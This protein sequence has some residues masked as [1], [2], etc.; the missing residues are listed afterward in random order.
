MHG[1]VVPN[2]KKTMRRLI[3]IF[4]L[5]TSSVIYSQEQVHCDV[6]NVLKAHMNLENLSEEI[7][8]DFLL[9]FDESCQNNVEYSEF[10]KETLYE[11]LNKDPLIL[12][13]SMDK[14]NSRINEDYIY[15]RL[16][17]SKF[18]WD[19]ILTQINSLD[20]ESKSKDQIIKAL[21]ISIKRNQK[22]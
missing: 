20:V 3:Q 8:K 16:Q 7:V 11:I 22:H 13:L 18:K 15:Y 19:D 5:T 9:T 21:E 6:N 4:L 2:A 10:S 14:F 12:I 1:T 17:R